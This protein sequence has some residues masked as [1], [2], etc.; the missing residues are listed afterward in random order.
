MDI[1]LNVEVHSTSKVIHLTEHH[2]FED[3]VV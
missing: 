3:P 1:C 2:A